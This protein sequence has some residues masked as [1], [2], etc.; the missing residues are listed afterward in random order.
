MMATLYELCVGNHIG[1]RIYKTCK[2]I[3]MYKLSCK[4]IDSKSAKVMGFNHVAW[5]GYIFFG[6]QQ[7]S[8][9]KA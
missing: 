1:L 3:H 8:D 2:H 4:I 6:L 7:Y 5:R 9:A